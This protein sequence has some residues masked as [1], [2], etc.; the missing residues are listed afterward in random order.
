M[1]RLRRQSL[2]SEKNE[3]NEKKIIIETERLILRRFRGE[4]LQDLY[5]YLSD[6]TAVR[7]EPY[8]PMNMDEV[9][10]EL[11]MRIATDEMIAVE[12]KS[13]HKFIGNVFLGKRD[14]DALELGY[15]F[16]RYFWGAGVCTGK[17]CR[18]DLQG[19]LAGSAQNLCGVRSVQH[20][21]VETA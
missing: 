9:K 16:N 14:C 17:L 11:D 10:N 21:V 12:L 1:I 19:F 2:K 3:M 13:V 15:V 20:G 6:E 8:R 5:E 7:F 4:D 18:A